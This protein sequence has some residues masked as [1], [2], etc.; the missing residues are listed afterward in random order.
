MLVTAGVTH[1]SSVHSGTSYSGSGRLMFGEGERD[2]RCGA[3][4][5]VADPGFPVRVG[6]GLQPRRGRANP[7]RACISKNLYVETKE[8]RPLGVG[9][10]P[11]GSANGEGESQ[12]QLLRK[13]PVRF[14]FG[15]QCRL[16]VLF[17]IKFI[18]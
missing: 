16:C 17:L 15:T 1:P 10:H 5:S 8:S 3:G 18:P 11:L 7:R 4:D 12:G 6:G 2:G 9:C 13:D 14:V